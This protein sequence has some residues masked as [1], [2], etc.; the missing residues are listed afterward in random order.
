[1]NQQPLHV[2]GARAHVVNRTHRVVRA[3]AMA[4]HAHKT[5]TRNLWVPLVI[6]SALLITVLY[7]AWAV[8]WPEGG[9]DQPVLASEP[10]GIMSML[11][12]WF[13]PVSIALGIFVL[14]RRNRAD[15]GRR[16]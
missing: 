11:F 4:M 6:C 13:L 7:A 14:V 5:R 9:A 2:Q 1:M 3:R 12:M 10:S 15:D 16:D 8:L